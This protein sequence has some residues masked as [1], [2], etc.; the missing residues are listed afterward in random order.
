MQSE[1]NM[2]ENLRYVKTAKVE[3]RSQINQIKEINIIWNINVIKSIL[4][5]KPK[6]IEKSSSW[7]KII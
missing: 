5:L 3:L 6:S 2:F 1:L 7:I 4:N